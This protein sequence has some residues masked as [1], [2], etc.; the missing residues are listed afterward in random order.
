MHNIDVK[1]L[2]LDNNA[3][4]QGHFLLSSGLHSPMYMQS[5]LVLSNTKNAEILGKMLAEKILE[6]TKNIDYVVSPALGGLIIGH[7]TAKALNKP[8]LFTERVDSQMVLRR[9]F[10]IPEN[11]NIVI[12]ED[13]FTTGKSTKEVMNLVSS[14]KANVV[15]CG[16][17]VNRNLEKIDFN[18]PSISLLN[19]KIDSYKPEECPLCKKQIPVEKPGSRFIKQ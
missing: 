18:V 5:A 10:N 8:F 19:L 2:F 9:G 7:E 3:L 17:I 1:K 11:S 16:S 13:V 15:A 12:I 14:Y 6:I 4:L